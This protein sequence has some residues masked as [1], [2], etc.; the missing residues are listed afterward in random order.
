MA[1]IP[2]AWPASSFAWLGQPGVDERTVTAIRELARRS[3]HAIAER[4]RTSG[5]VVEAYNASA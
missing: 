5:A 2:D 1:A 4:G 3:G